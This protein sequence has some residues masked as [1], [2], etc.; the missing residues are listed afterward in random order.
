VKPDG[1]P[2]PESVTPDVVKEQG[3]AEIRLLTQGVDSALEASVD[4]LAGAPA[5]A[6]D[7]SR[8]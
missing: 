3:E 4:A 6:A 2:Y 5:L 1:T 7:L 8:P